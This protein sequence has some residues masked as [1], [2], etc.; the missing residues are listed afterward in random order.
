[1]EFY[2]YLEKFLEFL[3]SQIKILSFFENLFFFNNTK[4]RQSVSNNIVYTCAYI[5]VHYLPSFYQE[6]QGNIT[7]R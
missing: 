3:L 7:R 5:Y 4:Y 2:R 1:M 6:S